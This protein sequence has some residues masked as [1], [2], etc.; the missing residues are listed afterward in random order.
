M[1]K[2]NLRYIYPFPLYFPSHQKKQ[3]QQQQQKK[4]NQNREAHW[5]LQYSATHIAMIKC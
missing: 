4:Q 5:L 3:Q 2:T 1:S